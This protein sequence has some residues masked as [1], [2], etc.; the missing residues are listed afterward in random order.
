[1]EL[2]RRDLLGAYMPEDAERIA[3]LY[4][5]HAYAW[6]ASRRS[7]HS[8]TPFEAGWLDRFLGL[9]PSRPS[10]LDLGCGSGE[11]IGR[12]LARRGC[13]LTGV[14]TSPEMMEL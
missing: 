7:Q 1:M 6:A 5:R 9:L 11:P 3:A 13:N 10:V 2:S 4:R 12:Y 8:D 14:D